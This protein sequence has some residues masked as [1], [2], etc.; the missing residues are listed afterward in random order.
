METS[1]EQLKVRMHQPVASTSAFAKPKLKEPQ[2]FKEP[3]ARRTASDFIGEMEKYL[4]LTGCDAGSYVAVASTYLPGEAARFL[5]ALQASEALPW[6]DF[7]QKLVQAF[8]A[9]NEQDKARHDLFNLKMTEA[10]GVETYYRRFM[11]LLTKLAVQPSVPDQIYMFRQGLVARLQKLT[12]WDPSNGMQ[13]YTDFAKLANC[14]IAN[15]K[16]S[17]GKQAEILHTMGKKPGGEG[18]KPRGRKP[19]Q[20]PDRIRDRDAGPSNEVMV[21]PGGPNLGPKCFKCKE[22]GH[23]GHD[24]P[25]KRQKVG[26][27]K[28]IGSNG[29]TNFKLK[30][31]H[32][33]EHVPTDASDTDNHD[34]ASACKE[35]EED[36]GLDVLFPARVAGLGV[37]ALLDSGATGNFVDA[38]FAEGH[39][40]RVTPC[41]VPIELADGRS[42]PASGEV[43]LQLR[44]GKVCE[45][46]RLVVMD[47][48]EG[49]DVIL[50]SPWLRAHGAVLDI[51]QGTC[52]LTAGDVEFQLGDASPK[53]QPRSMLLNAMQYFR[54]MRRGCSAFLG[55][56]RCSGTG[57]TPSADV[58]PE[59]GV[60]HSDPS[61]VQSADVEHVSDDDDDMP[62]LCDSDDEDV[63][64]VTHTPACQP[65]NRLDASVTAGDAKP[66]VHASMLALA[67]TKMSWMRVTM[68]CLSRCT[69]SL[70]RYRTFCMR[71]QM[72]FL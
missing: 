34:G 11:A 5:D 55:T 7:K 33:R 65:S 39:K 1:W 24:C 50:G 23:I 68:T 40:L 45:K 58:K 16:Q 48:A 36:A 21:A 9:I 42:L 59:K 26:N 27:A 46:T 70:Q 66:N 41:E 60:P 57:V 52:K 31:R 71:M 19:F 28:P 15:G 10:D 64:N 32:V 30:V 56:I 25:N 20:K 14:A 17:V 53:P 6:L 49:F 62:D 47:L 18:G 3:S 12:A 2:V 37:T 8:D 38:S 61:S 43:L 67:M 35:G 44:I 29:K 22:F 63:I 72:F 13:G 51:Q 54:A 4:R 69:H